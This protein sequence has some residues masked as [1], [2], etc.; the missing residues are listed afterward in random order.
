MPA[1]RRVSRKSVHGS[2]KKSP[3]PTW[4][5]YLGGAAGLTG[6]GGLGA[7]AY[8]KLTGQDPPGAAANAPKANAAANKKVNAAN[9]KA[10]LAPLN[11]PNRPVNEP[12]TP[13]KIPA[14]NMNALRKAHKY[15]MTDDAEAKRFLRREVMPKAQNYVQN[16]MLNS[17]NV[18]S[19][20]NTPEQAANRAYYNAIADGYNKDAV[21]KAMVNAYKNK[22][23]QQGM[24]PADMGAIAAQLAAREAVLAGRDPKPAAQVAAHVATQTAAAAEQTATP[25]APETVL[26]HAVNQSRPLPFRQKLSVQIPRP[27][28]YA[29]AAFATPLPPNAPLPRMSSNQENALQRIANGRLV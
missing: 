10:R 2:K 18:P 29:G 24:T 22:A 25:V 11:I 28:E 9:F 1:R 23:N 13:K 19:L 8:K 27:A 3:I 5:K 15:M 21:T 16:V 6:L 17:G 12:N 7:L 14:M 20:F 26:Q 4:A